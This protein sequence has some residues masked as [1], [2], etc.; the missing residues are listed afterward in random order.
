MTGVVADVADRRMNPKKISRLCRSTNPSKAKSR[1]SSNSSRLNDLA[2]SGG[3]IA[4]AIN[5]SPA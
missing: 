2:L 5:A 1:N 4:V 3:R